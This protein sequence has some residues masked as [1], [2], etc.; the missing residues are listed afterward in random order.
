M[1]Q[2]SAWTGKFYAFYSGAFFTAATLSEYLQLIYLNNMTLARVAPGM[3]EGELA[4]T[5]NLHQAGM[6]VTEDYIAT[7]AYGSDLLAQLLGT[8]EQLA[9]GKDVPGLLSK[10]TDRLVYY[11]G[12]DINIYFL[13]G[14]GPLT[15]IQC[16]HADLG[17]M[18]STSPFC[19]TQ[20]P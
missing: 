18:S 17:L 4:R 8:I 13:W 6:D 19:G 9:L 20:T 14:A 3:S 11:A 10:P 7:Q 5:L 1:G 15:L 12:H 16:L 2:P